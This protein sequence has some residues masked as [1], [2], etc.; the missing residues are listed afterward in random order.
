MPPL[1]Q[2]IHASTFQT[3]TGPRFVARSSNSFRMRARTERATTGGG[4]Y[5]CQPALSCATS[6]SHSGVPA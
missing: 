2:V 5:E 4:S 1:Q 6:V 3:S